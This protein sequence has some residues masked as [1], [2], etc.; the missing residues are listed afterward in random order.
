MNT[1]TLAG[2]VGGL[3][4]LLGLFGLLMGEGQFLN[5]MNIDMM[6]DLTRITLGAILIGS[7]FID[8][9]AARTA[10]GI[11]GVVYLGAFLASLFSPTLFGALPGG[12][13]IADAVI[14]LGGGVVGLGL[15]F[16]DWSG[17]TTRTG[18]RLSGTA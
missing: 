13:S 16:M 3:V 6:L 15:A 14:H 4:L 18:K 17:V 7:A 12:H 5:V 1:K 8:E 9:R 2:V 11:F 10:F